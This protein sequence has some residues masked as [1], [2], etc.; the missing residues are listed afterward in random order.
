M[1]LVVV[2]AALALVLP[3]L[4][5]A[6]QQPVTAALAPAEVLFE[7]R[8]VGSD[9]RPTDRVLM[10]LNYFASG[11]TPAEARAAAVALCERLRVIARDFGA[12]QVRIDANG[13]LAAGFSGEPGIV[14]GAGAEAENGRAGPYVGNGM[15][16]LRLADARR[17]AELRAALE[18]AGAINITGPVNALS[19]DTE[20]RRAARSNAM[21]KARAE[22]EQ[23]AQSQNLRVARLVRVSD[24]S[25]IQDEAMRMMMSQMGGRSAA[26]A[27]Q[28]E[29]SVTLEV[30]FV[31]AP[32]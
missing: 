6:A 18:Q 13:A 10:S 11:A 20:A 9:S 16:Q 3:A 19:D 24:A 7:V 12:E 21:A 5:G 29:T 30:G 31:L 15:M 17:F 32:R 23:F 28:V 25:T 1:R 26:P 8:A 27:G 14:S 4:A 22:A 2:A